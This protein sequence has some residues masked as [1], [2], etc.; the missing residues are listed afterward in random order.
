[1]I[2]AITA[3]YMSAQARMGAV[4]LDEFRAAVKDCAVHPVSVQGKIA[5]AVIVNGA[6]VHAC[7]LPW[8]HKRWF[9]RG[10]ARI[11]NDIIAKHGY[12]TTS[13]TTAAGREFVERLGFKRA[14]QGYRK[15]VM[16]GH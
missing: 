3:A 9:G 4:T 11:L 15:E 1:M 12:A 10:Q 7:I 6:E 2:D 8:A 5:G 16:Y 14:G 13:A